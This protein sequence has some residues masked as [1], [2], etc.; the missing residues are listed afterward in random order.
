LSIFNP[1]LKFNFR[2]RRN[3][4]WNCKNIFFASHVSELDL[5]GEY[6]ENNQAN[7]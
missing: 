3:I 1:L 2:N 5:L 4:F 7:I 6:N